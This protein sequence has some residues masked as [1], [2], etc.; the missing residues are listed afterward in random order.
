MQTVDDI[1]RASKEVMEN[2]R[3]AHLAATIS[4]NSSM[5]LLFGTF[6]GHS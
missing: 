3:S 6:P 2:S 1:V 5:P 4:V